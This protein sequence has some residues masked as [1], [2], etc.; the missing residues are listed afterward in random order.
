MRPLRKVPVVTMVAAAWMVRPSR[1][2]RP[3]TTVLGGRAVDDEVE[4]SACLM[5]RFGWASSTSRIFTR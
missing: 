5:K 4:T 2:F 3:R 1:S